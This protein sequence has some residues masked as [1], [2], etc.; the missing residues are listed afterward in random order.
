MSFKLLSQRPLLLLL[1]LVGSVLFLSMPREVYRGD[2][3]A[4]RGATLSLLQSGD[5]A[6]HDEL[7]AQNKEI[8]AGQDQAYFIRN[9]DDGRYFSKWGFL[10]TLL[11]I[12]PVSV[13]LLR[14]SDLSLL[15]VRGDF[16]LVLSLYNILWALGLTIYL[17]LLAGLFVQ[18]NSIKIVYILGCLFSSFLWNFLRAQTTEIFQ[19]FFFVACAYHYFFWLRKR[20]E[21]IQASPEKHLFVA[22][23]YVVLLCW[24][25]PYF[26]LLLFLLALHA[27][28]F[29][30][31]HEQ[32]AAWPRQVGV[33]LLIGALGLLVLLCSHEYKFG[34]PFVSGYG[35]TVESNLG[36]DFT[37]NI[38]EGLKGLLFSS[39]Y[40]VFLHFPLL[41][42]SLLGAK[43]FWTKYRAHYSFVLVVA[44]VFFCFIAKMEN[45]AGHWS[46][47]PRY[48]LF[49]L[50]VLSLPAIEL[51]LGVDALGKKQR[52]F[53][54]T[55]I[56]LF[57]LF[58]LWLQIQV[59]SLNFFIS[60][61]V[62][63]EIFRVWAPEG[64]ALE[65]FET[66][67]FSRMNYDLLA[68]RSG[69]KPFYP[70]ETLKNLLSEEQMGFIEHKIKSKLWI[71][72]YWIENGL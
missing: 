29:T 52:L 46:Y 27:A 26:V 41:L 33:F 43:R 1:A 56:L 69:E 25:K 67:N 63:D 19:V 49:F 38:F 34:S 2:A 71:N 72:Y 8:I 37:G 44:L 28:W 18:K 6:I 40:G 16:G 58:T 55:D 45:W 12:P 53:Y 48:V 5:L 17:W 11:Y 66:S 50:P 21:G 59:N 51:F 31:N 7:L 62:R 39:N 13:Q 32:Q 22:L 30:L 9:E 42:L 68:F 4:I 20:E 14:D 57:L 10:N 60:Y 70:V 61:E 3:V 23:I 54:G 64:R 24:L 35:R 65:Y 47:G 15:A 36:N